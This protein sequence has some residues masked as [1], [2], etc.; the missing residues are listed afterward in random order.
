MPSGV[1][2]AT[3]SGAAAAGVTD[4]EDTEEGPSATSGL[5]PPED[6]SPPS[7]A[8]LAVVP[9]AM[10]AAAS[11]GAAAANG[12]ATTAAAAALSLAGVGSGVAGVASAAGAGP[13]CGP[14]ASV[15]EGMAASGP[16]CCWAA[17]D[18]GSSDGRLESTM[19]AGLG[20]PGGSLRPFAGPALERFSSAKRFSPPAGPGRCARSAA[21]TE[22]AVGSGPAATAGSAPRPARPPA[23]DCG[24]VRC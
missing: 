10:T 24:R 19:A 5:P 13:S 11:P 12:L 6:A 3:G 7:G 9:G 21:A 4:G 17:V 16:G 1:L 15:A 22:A 20:G 8:G 23:A 18:W 14:L 2:A